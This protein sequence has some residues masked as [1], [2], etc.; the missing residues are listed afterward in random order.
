MK[1]RASDDDAFVVQFAAALAR[2]YDRAK[3]K[4]VTDQAF[5]ESIGVERPSLDRYLYGKSMPS[6]RTVALAHRDYH[7]AVPYCGVSLQD[8]LPKSAGKKK[9]PPN[10]MILPFVIQ[11]KKTAARVELKL[12]PLSA[13]KF[14]LRLVIDHAG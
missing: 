8:A 12:D 3:K 10:Q 9:K 14:E 1:K 7:I 13:R 2:E 6:V 4:G 5:A 11:P